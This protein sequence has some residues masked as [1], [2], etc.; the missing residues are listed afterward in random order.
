MRRYTWWMKPGA[1]PVPGRWTRDIGGY[2]VHFAWGY[3]GQYLFVV[4]DLELVVVDVP[5]PWPK[6]PCPAPNGSAMQGQPVD[7][8]PAKPS[9]DLLNRGRKSI[10]VDL[11]RREG[12][13]LVLRLV[14]HADGLLEGSGKFM[15]HVKLRPED[16]VD[17]AA[18]SALIRTAYEDMKSR[19]ETESSALPR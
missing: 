19:L 18:L 7:G 15:R 5:L 2:A 9:L 8:D 4:P 3:G 12:V 17:H 6:Q 11:K 16:D 10:G 1:P 14:E 13:D